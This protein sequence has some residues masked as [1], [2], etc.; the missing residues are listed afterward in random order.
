MFCQREEAARNLE[1]DESQCESS[2]ESP[3]K[4]GEWHES[5]QG[6]QWI[7]KSVEKVKKADD[8]KTN[9]TPNTKEGEDDE[10]ETF[11]KGITLSGAQCFI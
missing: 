1:E 2:A 6:M 9:R 7:A 11:L 5:E 3:N 10:E 8:G 4:S